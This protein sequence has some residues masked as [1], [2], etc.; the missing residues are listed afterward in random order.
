MRVLRPVVEAIDEAVSQV[1]Q[2]QQFVSEVE[3]PP[4]DPNDHEALLFEDMYYSYL[5]ELYA[6]PLYASAVLLIAA[7]AESE[8]MRLCRYIGEE[9]PLP[10]SVGQLRGSALDRSRVYLTQLAAW[11]FP[12]NRTWNWVK[13]FFQVR[14]CLAHWGGQIPAPEAEPMVNIL[15]AIRRRHHGIRIEENRG[16]QSLRMIT[17][18]GE[19]GDHAGLPTGGSESADAKPLLGVSLVVERDFC[20]AALDQVQEVF[21]V[22]HSRWRR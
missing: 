20:F 8:L 17:D 2:T 5:T 16:E 13:D 15:K 3:W 21:G 22:L 11:E 12:T 7:T 14:H 4:P 19:P 18:R 1:I 9:K 10:L 6:P